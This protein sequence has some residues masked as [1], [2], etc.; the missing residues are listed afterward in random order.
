MTRIPVYEKKWMYIDRLIKTKDYNACDWVTEEINSQ[1]GLCRE[2]AWDYLKAAKYCTPELIK[3][4]GIAS[5]CDAFIHAKTA[6]AE[7]NKWA[8]SE[9]IKQRSA[10]ALEEMI[11]RHAFT[12]TYGIYL[13]DIKNRIEAYCEMNELFNFY[14]SSQSI[15]RK[16]KQLGFTPR[17]TTR[18]TLIP[19]LGLNPISKL[20]DEA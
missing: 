14:G 2:S 19:S 17:R 10:N 3:K 4:S 20:G 5:E 12:S 6:A 11:T 9:N 7:Y 15:N 16:L 18:G 13:S 8:I 1:N